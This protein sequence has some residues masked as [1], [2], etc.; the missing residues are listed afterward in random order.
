[1]AP[2]YGYSIVHHGIPCL[3]FFVLC[4]FDLRYILQA[5]RC[6]GL[7]AQRE[8]LH[9]A[10]GRQR[11]ALHELEVTRSLLVADLALTVHAQLLLG[12]L[13]T[14]PL[15]H[16]CEQFLA[17]VGIRDAH[18]LHLGQFGMTKEEFLDLHREEVFA[19]ANHHILEPTYDVEIALHVHGRQVARM[20]PAVSINGLG[21]LL[22]H[23]VVTSHDHEASIAKFA[24]LT[25]WH[26]LA[27]H[28]IDDF[29][30]DM[31]QRFAD[32]RRFQLKRIIRQRHRD[33]A[34]ALRLPKTDD[35]I[36]SQPRFHLL[37]QEKRNGSATRSHHLE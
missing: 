30:L 18:H 1:M 9:L 7:L 27:G 12:Q 36:R 3:S 32:G 4:C 14:C 15:N 37:H 34:T 5:Q 2:S 31:W 11:V 10:T 29:D 6:D 28:R 33:A 24:A 25:Y 8:L 23:L 21:G 16:H 26:D 19:S 22:G 17:K 35:D 20:R 13:L